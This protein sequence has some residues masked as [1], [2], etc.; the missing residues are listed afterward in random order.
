MSLDHWVPCSPPTF[1]LPR[2]ALSWWLLYASPTPP[3]LPR[4]AIQLPSLRRGECCGWCMHG[5][6]LWSMCFVFKVRM[7]FRYVCFLNVPICEPA[8]LWKLVSQWCL[9]CW[10]FELSSF[11]A[12]QSQLLPHGLFSASRTFET[13]QALAINLLVIA[14]FILLQLI[15]CSGTVVPSLSKHHAVWGWLTSSLSWKTVLV[16]S[17]SL[18]LDAFAHGLLL[19]ACY[20]FTL[21][22]HIHCL[23]CVYGSI[24]MQHLLTA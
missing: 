23:V 14:S 8:F 13:R 7:V 1:W 5:F 19:S 15:L 10:L 2:G 16:A 4:L 24:N 3:G 22:L 9:L 6:V 11:M 12:R 20:H 18:R 17:V 21:W